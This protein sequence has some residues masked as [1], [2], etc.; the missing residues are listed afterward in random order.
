MT[1]L[2][3]LTGMPI[4]LI[5]HGGS[6]MVFTLVGLGIVNNIHKMGKES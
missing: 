2:I 5:S 3:P 4:P 1:Q 6:S